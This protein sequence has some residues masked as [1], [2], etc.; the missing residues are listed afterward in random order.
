M[1]PFA[2]SS[3]FA[4]RT[5]A[6]PVPATANRTAAPAAP[7]TARASAGEIAAGNLRAETARAVDAPEQSAIA[8]RLRDQETS[9]NSIRR[10][11]DRERPAGPPPAFDESPLERQARVALDPPEAPVTEDTEAA[12]TSEIEGAPEEYPAESRPAVLTV[13]PPPT[14]SEKAEASFAETRT[15]SEPRDTATLDRRN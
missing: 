8:P 1:I 14:P 5:A 13:E 7:D 2:P 4:P 12:D 9:E 11:L 10:L 15:I 6:P 3:S